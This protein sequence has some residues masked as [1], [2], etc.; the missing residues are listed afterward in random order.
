PLP[1]VSVA[2]VSDKEMRRVSN[3][4]RGKDEPT[5]VLSFPETTQFPPE[6]GYR[7]LGEIVLAP[8]T[9]TRKG[10][11]IARLAVHGLLHLL[12]YTHDGESDTM[13]MERLESEVFKEA[14]E[15]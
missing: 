7:A 15:S 1:L 13:E 8:E 10:E 5:T 4:T 9:I 6:E 11:D 2:L 14:V 12:G 3:E